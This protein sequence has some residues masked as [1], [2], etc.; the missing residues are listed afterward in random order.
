MR[1]TM[2]QEPLVTL[3]S[4]GRDA[5]EVF[6]ELFQ[7][8]KKPF[9]LHVSLDR[10]LYLTLNETPFLRALQLLCE[11]TDTRFTVREGVYLILPRAPG[12]HPESSGP[13]RMVRLVGNQMTLSQV[14]QAIEAQ[15][16]VRIEVAPGTPALRFNLDL[17]SVEVEAALDALCKGTGLR[18][19]RMERGYRIA[20][21]EPPRLKAAPTP[22]PALSQPVRGSAPPP[23]A[24]PNRVVP[25]DHPLK[26][27][28]CRYTL[29]LEW[30]YCPI[31]G[32]WVKPLTDR[33]KQAPR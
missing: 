14:V 23:R 21:V 29:Q 7:Q 33:A 3:E 8:V 20:P 24:T 16:G 5:R 28:K 26:C 4:R 18:W 10:P 9:V 6:A 22:D 19:E 32:A 2:P 17:P 13:A 30:R 15:A 11:A 31:C 25:P 1:Q 27:P 12:P